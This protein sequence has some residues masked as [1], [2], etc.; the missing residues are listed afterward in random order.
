LLTGTV[1]QGGGQVRLSVQLLQ[2][3]GELLWSERYEDRLP[4]LSRL[5]S[6][7]LNGLWEQ[8]PLPEVALA[9]VR[10]GVVDCEY[11][12]GEAAIRGLIEASAELDDDPEAGILSLSRL[13]ENNPANGLLYLERA[14]GY[15]AGVGGVAP[16]R[17]P[18]FHNLGMNDLQLSAE[19][20]PGLPDVERLRL[21]HTG[22]LQLDS[23]RLE[24]HLSRYPNSSGVLMAASRAYI[25]QGRDAEA[26]ALAGEAWRLDPLGPEATCEYRLQ[27]E[28]ADAGRSEANLADLNSWL[29]RLP[30]QLQPGCD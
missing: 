4:D 17:K 24:A 1:N 2:G 14:R 23:E 26:L 16:A 5:Q 6:R 8:L 29:S 22:R 25:D 13:I 21:L 12:A 7:V 20:C 28:A 3:D 11:T 18:V 27:L 10:D 30:E 15:F 19:S 9:D